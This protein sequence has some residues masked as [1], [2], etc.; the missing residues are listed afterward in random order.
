MN[1]IEQVVNNLNVHI[2][3]NETD[4]WLKQSEISDGDL[5]LIN[6]PL[7]TETRLIFGKPYDGEIRDGSIKYIGRLYSYGGLLYEC[8]QDNTDLNTFNSQNYREFKLTANGGVDTSTL[9]N[10]YL[11]KTGTDVRTGNLHCIGILSATEN[12]V[13]T[14]DARL[15]TDIKKIENPLDKLKEISGYEF[16]MNGKKQIGVLAQEV[17]RVAPEVVYVR[18]DGYMGVAYQNLIALLIESNKELL[19]RIEVLENG[20][21]L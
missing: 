21:K 10:R 20:N 8:L 1:V 6:S 9:D 17:E 16:R 15:K 4:Y 14:S 18:E 3:D 19:K 5:V 11:L 7:L 13:L 12:I 2:F